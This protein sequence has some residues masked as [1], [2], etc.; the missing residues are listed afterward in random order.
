MNVIMD[1]KHAKNI[2]IPLK[3]HNLELTLK[4]LADSKKVAVSYK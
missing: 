3:Y 1:E 2:C 4:E